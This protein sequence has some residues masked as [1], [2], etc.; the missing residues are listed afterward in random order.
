MFYFWF[1]YLIVISG[2]SLMSDDTRRK[3]RNC[4]VAS[5]CSRPG[6]FDDKNS[7]FECVDDNSSRAFSLFQIFEDFRGHWGNG[8]LIERDVSGS[9]SSGHDSKVG[10][11]ASVNPKVFQRPDIPRAILF[12]S[13]CPICLHQSRWYLKPV[14][15]VFGVY[16]RAVEGV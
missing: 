5:C 11:C 13:S 6:D 4:L 10:I 2:I 16:T 1:V 9:G 14:E 3:K 15:T 7:G 8:V 12:L